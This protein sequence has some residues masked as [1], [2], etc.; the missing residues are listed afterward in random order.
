MSQKEK[1]LLT[2]V[3]AHMKHGALHHTDTVLKMAL[4]AG[5]R[6]VYQG[7]RVPTKEQA[8]I[9]YA[10]QEG[11]PWHADILEQLA[12]HPTMQFVFAYRSD[13]KGESAAKVLKDVVGPTDPKKAPEGTVRYLAREAERTCDNIVHVSDD[14]EQTIRAELD[15]MFDA[16][17]VYDECMTEANLIWPEAS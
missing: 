9:H 1:E 4:A 14:N 5:L 12:D 11:K 15:N 2:I 3:Y 13:E 7:H 6:L 16:E 17:G 10:A 8:A